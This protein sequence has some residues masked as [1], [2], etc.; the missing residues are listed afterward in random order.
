MTFYCIAPVHCIERGLMQ[1]E[2]CDWKEN[3]EYLASSTEPL[4]SKYTGSLN[5]GVC[6][7][8][9]REWQWKGRQC[10]NHCIRE[11]QRRSIGDATLQT[12]EAIPVTFSVEI[13]S[14]HLHNPIL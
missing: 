14:A 4:G 1:C 9:R 6:E 8:Q 10:S 3:R 12:P 13:G 2:Y 5:T 7:V 11:T